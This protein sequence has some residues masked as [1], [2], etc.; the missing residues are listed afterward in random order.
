MKI[1]FPSPVVILLTM[2]LLAAIMTWIIPHG[3]FVE[4]GSTL[5]SLYEESQAEKIYIKT[6]STRKLGLVDVLS[7]PVAGMF[8]AHEIIFYALIMGGMIGV[9]TKTGAF[10]SGVANLVKYL[11]G[12]EILLIPILMLF[13]S[14]AGT[15]FGFFEEAII[16]YPILYPILISSGFDPVVCVAVVLFGTGV[17]CACSTVN[18]FATGIASELAGIPVGEGIFLRVGMLFLFWLIATVYIMIYAIR[19]QNNPATSVLYGTTGRSFL[20]N[21]PK[22]RESKFTWRHRLVL[23]LLVITIALLT[24]GVIPWEV[25]FGNEA[26][27]DFYN[28]IAE[29]NIFGLEPTTAPFYDEHFASRPTHGAPFG[30]WQLGQLS[31]LFFTSSMISGVIAGM[32]IT[33]TF[34]AFG[35]GAKDMLSVTLLLAVA[36]GISVIFQT[37]E[38][39]ATIIKWAEDIFT[40]WSPSLFILLTFLVFMILSLFV[41]SSTGLAAFT[42]PIFAPISATVYAAAGYTALLGTSLLVTTYQSAVGIVN[43]VAPT[44]V[45]LMGSLKMAGISYS[46]WM[47][48]AWKLL[49]IIVVLMSLMFVGST[50]LRF[51]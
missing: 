8:Q 7:A 44:S 24:I 25:K 31:V 32:G 14:L 26:F 47:K 18:P 11:Q 17:G 46:K 10:T 15:S 38:I 6:K 23:I 22:R 27:N 21:L 39:N 30:Y 40:G 13:F 1:K 45:M 2:I 50:A 9:I 16:F 49:L 5:K 41:T 29:Y 33:D 36:R 51:T 34:E 43:L 35:E 20:D 4:R 42:I 28:S 12:R 48:F 19:V 37:G 3:K